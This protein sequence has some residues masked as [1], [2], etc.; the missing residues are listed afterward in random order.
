MLRVN[1]LLE[2]NPEKAI[3]NSIKLLE[4]LLEKSPINLDLSG[5]TFILVLLIDNKL[6]CANVG[7]SRAILSHRTPSFFSKWENV[8]LSIDHKP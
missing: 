5:S 4:T 3:Y 8:P 7:D 6:Y 1:P 2:S